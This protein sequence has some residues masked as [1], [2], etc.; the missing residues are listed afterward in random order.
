MPPGYREPIRPESSSPVV[1]WLEARLAQ[2][3][4]RAA[5]LQPRQ[6]YDEPLQLQVLAFQHHYQ[7]VTDAVI[8][9]Q[10]LIQ[11]SA[12][13]EPGVP[14]LSTAEAGWE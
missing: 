11:L 14:L 3:Q 5:A 10:T 7:L 8:G 1:P 4:G 12:L 9:P 6:H 2:L 13:T